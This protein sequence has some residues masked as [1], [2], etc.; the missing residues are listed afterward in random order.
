MR[1]RV[2]SQVGER[3]GGIG[4]VKKKGLPLI[5][6][7]F[8]EPAQTFYSPLRLKRSEKDSMETRFSVG[9]FSSAPGARGSKR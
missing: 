1:K 7:V 6:Q 5:A 3:A 8:Q 2:A 9:P 4:P